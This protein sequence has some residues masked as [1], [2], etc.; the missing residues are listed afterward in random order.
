LGLLI[1]AF[2]DRPAIAQERAGQCCQAVV[3]AGAKSAAFRDCPIGCPEMVV[4][5]AGM[6]KMGSPQAEAGRDAGEG[7]LHDV[8]I[9]VPFA[10][11]KF[12]V[13]VEEWNTCA[14]AAA[15]PYVPEPWGNGRMPAVNVSWVDAKLYVAWLSQ[16]TG[17]IYRLPSEAEWEYAARG[18]AATPYSWGAATGIGHA[19]CD[20]CGSPWDRQQAA[21]V[22]SFLPNAFGLHDMHGNVW[23][24]VEDGWHPSYD[25]A[26]MDGSQ[27]AQGGDETFRIVRG[28]SWR[29][30]PD[31]LRAA[32][33]ARRNAH[34]RFD[35][36][37]FRV[38]RTLG[39]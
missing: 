5:P 36:L 12:E 24:W 26:P 38:A 31:L 11:S 9:A 17:K 16:L 18:D 6:F 32:A 25:G 28:G 22:G 29:N 8:A 39:P 7:P 27:W 30:E 15:C 13:T 23:E 1:G 34:V 21:P 20:G 10:V 3:P 19:N 35:T 4:I 37:G 14:A 33:R 2:A